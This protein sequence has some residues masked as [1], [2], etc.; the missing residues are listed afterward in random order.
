MLSV[1]R[2][3]RLK[4]EGLAVDEVLKRIL[5]AESEA[6]RIVD[7]AYEVARRMEAEARREAEER[8]KAVYEEIMR[9]A[10]RE[11]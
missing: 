7:S 3:G 11:A 5:E 8:A 1:R 2:K 9:E 4:S 6:R 10:E